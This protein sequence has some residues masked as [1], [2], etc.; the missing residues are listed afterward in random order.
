MT[1]VAPPRV[2]HLDPVDHGL[3]TPAGGSRDL[4]AML[5]RARAAEADGATVLVVPT[6]GADA[7][8]RHHWPATAQ[9]LA[10]LLATTTARVA[11]DVPAAA[12][13]P[14]ALARFAA[15]A[16]GLA[17]G[18]LVIRAVGAGAATF[19]AELSARWPGGVVV[20][21]DDAALA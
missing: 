7:P 13:D 3:V 17:G 9:A 6:A 16:S 2:V 12:W 20:G 11:L 1:T 15:S 8:A 4:D 19:A 21:D 5:D 14:T 10:V 18:R